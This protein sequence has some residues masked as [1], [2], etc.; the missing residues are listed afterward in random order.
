MRISTLIFCFSLLMICPLVGTTYKLSHPRQQPWP[1]FFSVFNTVLGALDYYEN[2]RDSKG[3]LVDFEKLGF[4]YDSKLGENWWSYYF[5]PIQLGNL[6]DEIIEFKEYKKITF[7]FF[8]QLKMSRER[9]NEL[10]TKY[11]KLKPHIQNKLDTLVKNNFE[12]NHVIGIHYRGTD[13]VAEARLVTF[14]AIGSH[15]VQEVEKN[16]NLKI[17]V[18]TDDENFLLYMYK[19]FPGKIIALN[20]LRSKDG[21]AIHTNLTE[22]P[23]QKGEEALLDCLLL[24]KCSKLFKTASNLSD[25]S[26]KF[27]PTIP[28]INISKHFTESTQFNKYNLF[29]V[30]ATVL[31]LL[32]S[33]E[34]DKTGFTAFFPTP[35]SNWWENHFEPLSVGDIHPNLHLSDVDLT[36]LGFN[37]LYELEAKKAYELINNYIQI[38]PHVLK[39]VEEIYAKKLKNYHTITVFYMKEKENDYQVFNELMLKTQTTLSR[40][41]ASTKILLISND[42]TFISL[43]NKEFSNIVY[44][45]NT[46]FSFLDGEAELFL[47][48]LMARTNY[49]IG[50]QSIYLKAIAQFNPQLPIIS[51]GNCWLEQ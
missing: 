9:S 11:I 50:S 8:A 30:F 49:L 19:T 42:P 7:S 18:A 3:F 6:D 12:G 25:V 33:Y 5:E 15:L 14:E 4:F 22:N 41:P 34:T 43:M 37:G 38:K 29:K 13:K 31:M 2:Q 46:Q 48:L 24:S 28:V 16:R 40:A 26:I 32:K 10:I 36:I 23:Y 1:G 47:C 39:K 17:F 27:N 35:E 51:V 20:A 45:S 21:T 44:P